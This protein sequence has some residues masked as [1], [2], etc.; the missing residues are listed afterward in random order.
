MYIDRNERDGKN[1]VDTNC[2]FLTR[3]AFRV[4]PGWGMMPPQLGAIGDSIFWQA[5]KA[6]RLATAHHPEPTVAFRTQYQVHYQNVGEPAPPGT[7]S[8]EDSTV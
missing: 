8:N 6:R 4:L 7:K 5:L 2:M 3:A 1:H